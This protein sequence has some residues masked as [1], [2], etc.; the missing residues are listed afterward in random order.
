MARAARAASG[1]RAGRRRCRSRAAAALGA[2]GTSSWSSG[3]APPWPRRRAPRAP[4]C[5]SARPSTSSAHRSAVATSSASPRTRCSPRGSPAPTSPACRAAGVAAC[6]KHLVAND[7]EHD[8]FEISSEPDE[9]TLRE[10]SLLPFE[11]ALRGGRG[12]VDDGGLQP[13]ARHALLGQRAAAHHDPPR[14]VGLGRRRRSPTGSPCTARPSRPSRGL[15]LEMPGPP[16]HWGAE[17]RRG[18]RARARSAAT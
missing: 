12:L 13:P 7:T 9:R 4:T 5:C 16:L 10:V 2:R 18:R 14:R 11:H 15:D 17:A 1:S 8:R 3:S 6:V